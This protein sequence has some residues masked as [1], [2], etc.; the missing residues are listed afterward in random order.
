LLLLSAQ[1]LGDPTGTSQALKNI[2]LSTLQDIRLLDMAERLEMVGSLATAEI[3]LG[4][5]SKLRRLAQFAAPVSQ[6]EDLVDHAVTR[7]Q[8]QTEAGAKEQES[9]SVSG[10]T[11][12]LAVTALLGVGGFI[13][14]SDSI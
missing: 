2:G 11:L 6:S 10:D 1:G 8:L 14:Q 13:L 5:R 3:I 12:T 4:D 9:L 7:R